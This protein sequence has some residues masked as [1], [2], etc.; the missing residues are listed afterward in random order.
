[1]EKEKICKKK[2]RKERAII[3]IYTNCNT[4]IKQNSQDR[5]FKI[6]RES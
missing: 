6:K 1:M 2:G 4:H 5:E 3:N